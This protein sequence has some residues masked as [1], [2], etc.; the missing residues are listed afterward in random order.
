VNQQLILKRASA[1]RSS[2]E[3][4][5]DDFDV[6]A[7]GVVVGRIATLRERRHHGLACRPV[8]V[9]PRL[10]YAAG[11]G[12]GGL[13]SLGAASALAVAWGEGIPNYGRCGRRPET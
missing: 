1:S 4:N 5:D 12:G 10:R 11:G 13:G 3:W 6:L 7:D 9:R 8:A 2:G